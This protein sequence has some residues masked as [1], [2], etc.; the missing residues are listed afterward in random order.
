ML[1]TEHVRPCLTLRLMLR[2]KLRLRLKVRLKL[3]L[4]LR[5]NLV[6]MER[7]DRKTL[8]KD[9]SHNTKFLKIKTEWVRV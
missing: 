6:K 5:L 3:R 4:R 1:C 8:K 7:W 2:L 9:Y